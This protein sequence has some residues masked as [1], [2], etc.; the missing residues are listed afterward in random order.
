MKTHWTE[1]SIKD[2]L[3]S[4][5][6]DFVAQLEDKMKTENKSQDELASIL[7]VSKGRVSQIFNN[8][9]NFGLK[10]IIKYA[11][12]LR[13]KVSIVAYDDNDPENKKGPINSD[14]FRKCWEIYG[15]PSDFWIFQEKTEKSASNISANEVATIKN[16][17]P[18]F[19]SCIL[20]QNRTGFVPFE[21]KIGD[22]TEIISD[23]RQATLEN[24]NNEVVELIH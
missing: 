13:M 23:S 20:N 6:F 5:A 24:I 12:A 21:F 3:F 17:Q 19:L 9:G 10:S 16:L 8:P 2:Y 11:R 15:K 14:I 7:G 18:K 4:I 22:I 1:K